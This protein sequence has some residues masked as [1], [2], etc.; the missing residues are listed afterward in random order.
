M[1]LSTFPPPLR[2]SIVVVGDQMSTSP[3]AYPRI[4]SLGRDDGSCIIV[5]V[6]CDGRITCERTSIPEV[7]WPLKIL[8]G[9]GAGYTLLLS[10]F[11]E[12]RGTE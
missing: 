6:L 11:R 2:R 4:V 1:A 10:I 7:S 9:E 8:Y 5:D 12:E 3:N